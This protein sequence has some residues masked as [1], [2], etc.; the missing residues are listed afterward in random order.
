MY[1]DVLQLVQLGL[2]LVDLVLLRS[3]DGTG[4]DALDHLTAG[5]HRALRLHLLQQRVDLILRNCRA[6]DVL[7]RRVHLTSLNLHVLEDLLELGHILADTSRVHLLHSLL[8]R[9]NTLLHGHAH[10]VRASRRLDLA[11]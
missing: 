1:S 8:K 10:L 6:V 4:T 5:S 9:R 2:H 3:R 11:R 7:K